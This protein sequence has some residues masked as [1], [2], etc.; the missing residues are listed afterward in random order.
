MKKAV[1]L[2][3]VIFST[4]ALMAQQK[5]TKVEIEI[6]NKKGNNYWIEIADRNCGAMSDKVN[7]FGKYYA[8]N[9]AATAKERKT[10]G[11]SSDEVGSACK[12]FKGGEKEGWRLPTASE[13]EAIM[14]RIEARKDYAV[15]YSEK[16]DTAQC[17][18]IPYASYI[19]TGSDT[20]AKV[21]TEGVYWSGEGRKSSQWALAFHFKEKFI[22]NP[23]FLKTDRLQ[24][25]CVRTVE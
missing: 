18:Y 21:G 9:M 23:I 11:T 15:I 14:K 1:F 5:E 7:S 24:V 8:W 12:N 13:M 6:K 25:R 3:T 16:G 20:P 22:N 10:P 19:P 2:M 17:V 4:L